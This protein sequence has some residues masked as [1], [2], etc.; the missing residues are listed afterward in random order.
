MSQRGKK[1][2]FWPFEV[3][4]NGFKV[5][6]WICAGAEF[7]ARGESGKTVSIDHC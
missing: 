6:K 3:G 4:V 5:G 1:F 2:K 7:R